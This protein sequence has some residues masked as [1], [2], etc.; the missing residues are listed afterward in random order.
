[1]FYNNSNVTFV[2]FVVKRMKNVNKKKKCMI[3]KMN[4][5]LT[6]LYKDVKVPTIQRELF[7]LES[8]GQKKEHGIDSAAR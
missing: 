6:L 8:L 7:R 3:I 1:M 5:L 4:E 2:F